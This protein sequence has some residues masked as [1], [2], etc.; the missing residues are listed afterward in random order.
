MWSRSSSFVDAHNSSYLRDRPRSWF[1]ISTLGWMKRSLSRQMRPSSQSSRL[2]QIAGGAATARNARPRCCPGAERGRTGSK[3]I[4]ADRNVEASAIGQTERVSRDHVSTASQAT[5]VQAVQSEQK[6]S[7][8]L[9]WRPPPTLSC[10]G[11][12]QK[13]TRARGP[14]PVIE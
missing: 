12:D 11:R 5:R 3:V 8:K 9:G 6:T 7:I 4:T 14:F 1:S 10:P 2:S 13:R